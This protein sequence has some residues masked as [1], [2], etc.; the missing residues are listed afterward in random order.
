MI[1]D[2]KSFRKD[3]SRWSAAERLALAALAAGI[4]WAAVGLVMRFG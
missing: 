2:I 1:D 3:W 4:L